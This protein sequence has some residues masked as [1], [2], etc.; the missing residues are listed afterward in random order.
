M[1]NDRL[2]AFDDVEAATVFIMEESCHLYIGDID[3]G[4][5][6]AEHLAHPGKGKIIKNSDQR[7]RFSVLTLRNN[8]RIKAIIEYVSN[9]SPYQ[10]KLCM[11]PIIKR[12]NI[13][14]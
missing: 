1:E 2:Q 10:I 14:L 3:S 9:I 7:K 5:I 4:E 8:I 13:R 11:S 6:I 12:I